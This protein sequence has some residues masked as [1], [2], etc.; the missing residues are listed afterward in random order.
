MESDSHRSVPF[1]ASRVPSQFRP[2][3]GLPIFGDG[4]RHFADGDLR[5][6]PSWTWWRYSYLQYNPVLCYIVHCR[7]CF[8]LFLPQVRRTELGAERA[9]DCLAFHRPL[10][11]YLVYNQLHA[12]VCG[13]D[14]GAALHHNFAA[15]AR[16][17]LGRIPA[18]R[19][20]R[21]CGPKHNS[22]L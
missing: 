13:F 8:R 7:I 22:R 16:L 20:W 11:P 12:L 19:D 6:F 17:R 10:F 9:L 14:P 4:G 3:R 15:H 2:R 21:H 18:H 1:P 5:R